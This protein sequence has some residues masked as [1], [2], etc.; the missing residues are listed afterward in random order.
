MA[1]V[2][3]AAGDGDVCRAERDLAGRGGHGGERAGAHAV[4]REA[5]NGLGQ[6]REQRDV[7]AERQALVADLRCR[8]EDDVADPLDRDLRVSAQQ[9][10]HDLHGHV[11]RARAPELAFRPGLA[12]GGAHAV[13]EDDLAELPCHRGPR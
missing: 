9:L 6:P 3:D 8:G 7:A 4:D 13:D 12:E 5:G 10:A 2:L 1:H 11:V